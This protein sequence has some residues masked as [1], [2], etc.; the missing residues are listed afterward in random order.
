MHENKVSQQLHQSALAE[1]I[2][3]LGHMAVPNIFALPTAVSP[4]IAKVL[5]WE[6]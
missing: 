1:L 5:N 6:R 4:S 3:H 2:L